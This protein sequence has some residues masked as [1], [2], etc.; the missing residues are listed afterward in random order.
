MS[1][2]GFYSDICNKVNYMLKNLTEARSVKGLR[3]DVFEYVCKDLNE[4]ITK[5]HIDSNF[6]D[7]IF[8]DEAQDF[9]LEFYKFFRLFK[10]K[11]LVKAA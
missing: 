8:I 2:R 11:V 4:Y 10:D 1:I 9:N 7:Y 5:N 6:Y 3:E